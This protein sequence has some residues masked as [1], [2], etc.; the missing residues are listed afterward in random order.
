[1]NETF[2]EFYEHDMVTSHLENMTDYGE[3]ANWESSATPVRYWVETIALPI[4]LSLGILGNLLNMIILTRK[5][6][7]AKMDEMEKSGHIFLIALAVSDFLFC[8]AEFPLGFM[9]RTIIYDTECFMLYYRVYH[10]GIINMFILS[11]TA[12]T[13][14]MAVSRATVALFPLRA[15]SCMT[16]TK[17]KVTLILVYV[18]SAIFAL[19]RY[20]TLKISN[21]G[22]ISKGMYM[23]DMGVLYDP[24]YKQGFLVYKLLW[25]LIGAVIPFILLIIS[26]V[27][28][29]K[30]LRKS[31]RMPDCHGNRSVTSSSNR[32]THILIAIAIIFLLLVFPA[33]LLKLINIFREDSSTS[34]IFEIATIIT[35]FMQ[36]LNFTVNFILYYSINMPFRKT[37]LDFFRS[38]VTMEQKR[39]SRKTNASTTYRHYSY[40]FSSFVSTPIV[41]TQSAQSQCIEMCAN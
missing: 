33:E 9:H 3:D 2:E 1:M 15:R 10:S 8:V 30:T 17:V 34:P 29:I 4:V 32:L 23:A 24:D 28:L 11:S 12:L 19:P 39:P 40:R 20:W 27:C 14:V 38:I 7:Q 22:T 13:V 41:S 37:V 31:F 35:N 36:S 16:L 6:L 5:R 21:Y 26:N 18:I 25:S